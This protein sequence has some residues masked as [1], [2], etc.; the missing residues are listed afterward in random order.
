MNKRLRNKKVPSKTEKVELPAR[1]AG[2]IKTHRL[3]MIEKQKELQFM[4]LCDQIRRN[5][6]KKERAESQRDVRREKR[7]KKFISWLIQNDFTSIY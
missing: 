7:L 5:D 3:I 6:F 2:L 1:L 4:I